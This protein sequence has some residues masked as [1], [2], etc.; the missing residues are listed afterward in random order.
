MWNS[1]E[2]H[3]VCSRKRNVEKSRKICSLFQEQ[4]CGTVKKDV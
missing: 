3:I 2:R 1:Q 4:K